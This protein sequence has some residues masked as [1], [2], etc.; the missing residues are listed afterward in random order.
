[1]TLSGPS[2]NR[3]SRF[4]SERASVV[5]DR[6]LCW[7]SLAEASALVRAKKISP[8]EL[9]TAVLQQTN[10]FEAEIGAFVSLLADSALN[11]ARR[12][13]QEIAKGNYR[14]ALHGIPITLKD[15]I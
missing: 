4:E 11:S 10:A 15:L 1:M 14:G 9:T 3:R 7:L 6:G 5:S 2:A 13:E 8:V 12:A